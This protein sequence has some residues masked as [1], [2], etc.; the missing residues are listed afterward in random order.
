MPKRSASLN[1]SIVAGSIAGVTKFNANLDL[2]QSMSLDA[3]MFEERNLSK[4]RSTEEVV[5]L[6][7]QS[8]SE[9]TRSQWLQA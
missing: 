7:F 8:V 3:D 6:Q 2:S 9:Y 5:P 4:D 1:Q